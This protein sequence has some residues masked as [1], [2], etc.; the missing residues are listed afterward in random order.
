MERPHLG[1]QPYIGDAF[2][3]RSKG[4]DTL[5]RIHLFNTATFMSAGTMAGDVPALDVAPERLVTALT[6]KLF[7]EDFEP[8]FQDLQD[9]EDEHEL[10]TT[11]FY[12][13]DFVNKTG[14]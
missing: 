5:E 4:E 13:P 9:W 3:L 12:A 6:Q 8:I 1:V 10:E 11:P 2:E 14:R 7:V